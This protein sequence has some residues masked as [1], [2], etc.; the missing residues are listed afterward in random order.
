M[1]REPIFGPQEYETYS[2]Y[3]ERLEDAG[4]DEY[5]PA[6]KAAAL[7]TTVMLM[8][9]GNK[10][11]RIH[12]Q[13]FQAAKNAL[14]KSPVFKQMM[15]S[16][17]GLRLIQRNDTDGLFKLLG[18]RTAK[19]QQE[20]DR[21]YKRSGDREVVA[22]DA[23]LL[24]KSIESLKNT[25]GTA[26][27]TGSPEQE[28][29]GKL[30]QEMMKQLEH[31]QALAEKGIQLSGEQTK[32]LISSVKADNDGGKQNVNPGGER[33][34]EGYEESMTLLKNYMPAARFNRY[35]N[36]LN[37][38]RQVQDPADPN[39]AAPEAFEP[40]RITAG[41]RPAKELIAD[42][43]RRLRAAF[44]T[45]AAAEALAIRQ[46]SKGDPNK[47]ISPE[48]L[49]RQTAKI[50]Q[51][52]TAFMRAMTDPRSREELE[53]LAEMGEADTVADEL[54]KE[55]L[56]ESRWRV[57]A[58]AQGEINRSIRRLTGDTPL[59]RH[60]TTQYLANILAAEQLAVNA[61][62]DETITNASFRERAEEM[63]K[64]PAFQ[65]LAERY[66]S[67]P[68]FRANMNR[69]LQRDHSA[70]SLANAYKLEQQPLQARRDR[71]QPQ[72][73]NQEQPELQPAL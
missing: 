18:E 34:A 31:A 29:R 64:D 5:T 7:M 46:L 26:A 21:K 1:P 15:E 12:K 4:L 36:R 2:Q 30:Y 39:Y 17:E 19:R 59:N 32:A 65:R 73:Q 43:R 28:R 14:T 20:L 56:E 33:Q 62:G 44:G 49:E 51:P 22:K 58:A 16:P 52:G 9:H 42:N 41:A 10:N 38:S 57:V 13:S 24:K 72:A 8:Q 23:E 70:L 71:E 37:A 68:A 60:F 63:Q 69:G 40:Q 27:A 47:L 11:A 6:S 45:E 3:K 35:C 61:K 53:R 66:I 25:A 48:E 54:G 55:I 67:N 50:N